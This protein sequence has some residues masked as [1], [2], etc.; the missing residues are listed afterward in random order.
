MLTHCDSRRY[1]YSSLQI[2]NEIYA[3]DGHTTSSMLIYVPQVL[4]IVNISRDIVTDSETLGRCYVPTE[5]MD[6]ATADVNTLCRDRD[7]WTLGSDKLKSY[8]TRM[9]RLAN[10]YQLESL[11]GIWHLPYE[12]RGPVLVATDIY[13]GVACA[14]EAS[15]TYPRRASL[16]KW[17][18]IL[19][20]VNSLY[21][22]SLRYFFQTERCKR[23]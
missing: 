20:G 1:F 14:V 19:V 21:F 8:A 5:Y 7:P 18:K 17:D 9:I 10:Q 13:R 2:F 11:E 3:Y 23:C 6:D 16:S 12:V 15:P 4:Q 22:K